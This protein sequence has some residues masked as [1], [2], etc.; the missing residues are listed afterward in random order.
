MMSGGYQGSARSISG[1]HVR[2]VLVEVDRI[3]PGVI[4]KF[5]GHA[6][7]AGMS[8]EASELTALNDVFVK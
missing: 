8:I 3:L 5:G 4:K 2:D 6:M 7:A 1:I